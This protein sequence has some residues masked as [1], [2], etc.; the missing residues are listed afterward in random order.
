[1]ST[2]REALKRETNKFTI[3]ITGSIALAVTV[4]VFIAINKTSIGIP[5]WAIALT[6]PPLA[7][8][9]SLVLS[10]I[11]QYS[12]CGSVN[13]AGIALQNLIV[14]G[15]NALVAGILF[16]ETFPIKKVL[17]GEFPP[18]NP[19]TGL[20][21]DPASP[22]FSQAMESESHYKL[23]FFSGIVKAVLPIWMQE[24]LKDGLAYCYWIFWMNLLPIYTLLGFQTACS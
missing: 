13:I 9:Y 11:S 12:S 2:T 7:Y 20:P 21:L 10:S 15:T 6:L 22:E 4:C 16:L 24:P 23:Q 17:F 3:A 18:T 14:L 1:M 19:L 5:S 8:G